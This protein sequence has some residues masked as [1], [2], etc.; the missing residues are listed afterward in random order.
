MKILSLALIA[1]LLPA[2]VAAETLVYFGTDTGGASKGI[3]VSTLDEAS[4]ALS[5]PRLAAAIGNPGFLVMHPS[6]PL[7]YS[8]AAGKAAD[9]AWK[10]EVAAF[11]VQPDGSLVLINTQPAGGSGPCHVAIDASGRVLLLANYNGGNVASYPVQADGS[12]GPAASTVP[13]EGAS[14]NPQRQK[15]PHPH[16]IYPDPS[17][18][19]AYVPDLGIDKVVIYRLDTASG[20]LSPNTPAHAT[21]EA[22]GGPRH[23]AFHPNGRWAYVNLELTSR[24]AAYR[25]DAATG[26]LESFQVL[27]S[28]PSDARADGNS[29]AEILVHPSGRFLYVSNRGHDSIA[30]FSINPQDG[31]LRFVETTPTGG[32]T[33]RSFG[34]VPGGRWLIAANQNGHNVRVFRIDAERGTLAATGSEVTVDRPS[35]VRFLRR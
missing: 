1:A 22:G 13:H 16:G 31:S 24:V 14:V 10:E 23:M 21:T 4:G 19:R 2:A 5:P 6:K 8:V 20:R 32:R 34:I 9:G 25:L 35:Y 18:K 27:S 29:T 28:L 30:V 33:P 15:E 11:A 7:V 26:A 17:Q 12:I 3:Y